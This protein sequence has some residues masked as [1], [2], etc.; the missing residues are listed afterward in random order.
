MS[1]RKPLTRRARTGGY[2]GGYWIDGSDTDT[3]IYGSVQ[4]TTGE[5]RSNVPQGYDSASAQLLVTDT[6]LDTAEAEGN[7]R[8]DQVQYR[9]KWYVVTVREAWQND[10]INHYAYIIAL[11][12]NPAA[13]T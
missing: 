4:P 1:F 3:T 13:R 5:Q 2:A 11:P 12:D 10:V 7:K 9:T 8:A 6:Q